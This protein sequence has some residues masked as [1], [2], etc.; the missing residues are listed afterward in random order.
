MFGQDSWE[1]AESEF[2]NT[3][4][5]NLIEKAHLSNDKIELYCNW[6]FI[7]PMLWLQL[8]ELKILIFLYLVFLELALQ[9]AKH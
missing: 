4:V 2:V 3:N 7:K 5:K 6:R 8:L 1:K 9:W